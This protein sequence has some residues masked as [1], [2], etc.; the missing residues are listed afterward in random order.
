M[1]PLDKIRLSGENMRLDADDID[2]LAES[3]KAI[4]LL[5][6]LVLNEDLV[7]VCGHRRFAAC[8]R[9]GLTEVPATVRAFTDE[10]AFVALFTENVHRK[11]LTPLEEAIALKKLAA[12][13]LTGKEISALIGKSQM[14]VSTYLALLELSD[15][16]Q[17]MVHRGEMSI[18]KAVD[19][20][21]KRHGGRASSI[22][23]GNAR[24]QASH[25][26]RVISILEAGKIADDKRI[27]DR[28]RLLFK[29]L[30]SYFGT[31][32]E[33][34]EQ[35]VSDERCCR[36]GECTTRLSRFNP[37][38]YCSSHERHHLSRTG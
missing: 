36:H 23:D 38:I 32:T 22:T 15:E 37:G 12:R 2:E 9:A 33:G 35:E 20:T 18:W 10:E 3:I 34:A 21:R 28:L 4:G 5:Q 16:L 6:P 24:W 11:H 7:L 25:L 26:D 17:Q 8:R 1:V 19:A 31:S 13:G 29:A 27:E 30:A 14:Y